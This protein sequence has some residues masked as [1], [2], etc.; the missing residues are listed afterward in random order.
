[1]DV[2][3][4]RFLMTGFIALF[5]L[6]NVYAG[7]IELDALSEYIEEQRQAWG[8]PGVAVAV[9]HNGETVIAEGFGVKELGKDDRVDALTQFAIASNSKTFTCAALAIAVDD[10]LLDWDDAVIDHLPEFRLSDPHRTMTMTVRDLV[11]HK[12]GMEGANAAWWRSQFDRMDLLSRM[13]HLKPVQ[14]HREGYY[15]NNLMYLVAGLVLEKASGMSWDE[16]V[17]S[18]I[19]AP[20]GMTN[21]TTTITGFDDSSN[22]A[23]PHAFEEDDSLAPTKWY[24]SD[25]VGPA[26]SVNSCAE[27]MAKWMRLLLAK[28]E[29]D[30]EAIIS[31]ESVEEMQTSQTV[32][33]TASLKRI[34]RDAHFHAYGLGHRMYDFR[35]KKYVEH[36]GHVVTFRSHVSLIPE[37]N[38]GVAVL[39]SSETDFPVGM[40]Y[41]IA[42]KWFG[43][44]GPDWMDVYWERHQ[45]WREDVA[46]DR[47]ERE[48]E[49]IA[50]APASLELEAYAG[51]YTHPIYGKIDVK[52]EDGG[53]SH[54]FNDTPYFIG[55]LKHWHYETFLLDPDLAF[56]DP[57]LVTFRLDQ[58]GSIE[59]LEI[60]GELYERSE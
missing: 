6:F 45:E 17:A 3:M 34:D 46:E 50:D 5:A 35:G 15:Y 54:R 49:R 51:T 25:Q 42:D 41:A 60:G 20:L 44:E 56:R 52:F 40:C 31:E 9:V 14:R 37:D 38:F 48:E 12:T 23:A 27:D 33:S 16:F 10:G 21:S 59:G 28:G 4:K 11:T 43:E 32:L 2:I 30:G 58:D 36:G 24:I 47:K 57:S 53:L 55:V 7:A 39:T 1:M 8:V 29:W 26:A 18:R 22:I 13:V 19:Y